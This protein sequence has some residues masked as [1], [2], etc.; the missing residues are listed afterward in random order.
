MPI[1][2]TYYSATHEARRIP[3]YLTLAIAPA[4]LHYES[5]KVFLAEAAT[6]EKPPSAYALE[7]QTRA[8]HEVAD[9]EAHHI[10]DYPGMPLQ[11]L[12]ADFYET[13]GFTWLQQQQAYWERISEETMDQGEPATRYGKPFA[14]WRVSL[15]ATTH[16]TYS[17]TWMIYHAWAGAARNQAAYIYERVTPPT[18]W[19]PGAADQPGTIYTRLTLQPDREEIAQHLQALK[20]QRAA[21]YREL[22]RLEDEMDLYQRVQHETAPRASYRHKR[23]DGSEVTVEAA[24]LETQGSARRIRYQIPVGL[25]RRGEEDIYLA[26]LRTPEELARLSER[27]A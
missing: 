4:W 2:N 16:D 1:T 18:D 23:G 12:V 9:F 10:W 11:S 27:E 13:A 17:A 6:W 21:S 20:Q 15:P 8:Q 22:N 14:Q 3:D 19:Q 5:A 26:W 25:Q 7:I 24:I